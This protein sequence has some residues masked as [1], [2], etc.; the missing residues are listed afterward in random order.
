MSTQPTITGPLHR[1]N[2]FRICD[3]ADVSQVWCASSYGAMQSLQYA[4]EKDLCSVSLSASDLVWLAVTKGKY[5]YGA[6]S[7]PGVNVDWL[8]QIDRIVGT[9]AL[10]A[11]HAFVYIPG[12]PAGSVARAGYAS[13]LGVYG[14]VTA[15]VV[16]NGINIDS[17]NNTDDYSTVWYDVTFP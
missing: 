9:A 4:R 17:W 5:P 16:T 2:P 12:I 6:N 7:L 8:Y 15:T 1:T 14:I 10:V 3:D 13:V 11:G